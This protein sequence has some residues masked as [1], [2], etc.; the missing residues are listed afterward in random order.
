MKNF[1][2][3]L[4]FLAALT[5]MVF[6]SA[7]MYSQNVISSVNV[8]KKAAVLINQ[9]STSSDNSE[10]ELNETENFMSA[11]NYLESSSSDYLSTKMFLLNENVIENKRDI[12]DWMINESSWE[13]E[14][15]SLVKTESDFRNIE[16]WMLDE[17]FWKI[18]DETDQCELEEWMTDNKF[19]VMVK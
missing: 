17:K 13:L 2:I 19:W 4:K 7:N 5:L 14:K 16:D 15:K 8:S 1:I 6:L 11:K 18:I 10:I 12:E 3:N 9:V